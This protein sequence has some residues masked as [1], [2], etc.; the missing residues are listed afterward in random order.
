MLKRHIGLRR[1]LVLWAFAAVMA[2]IVSH[3]RSG[4]LSP[5][6]IEQYKDHHPLGAVLLFLSIYAASVVAALPSLPLN[7]AAGY[8]WGGVLGGPY[9]TIGAT[10]G[11]WLSFLVALRFASKVLGDTPTG[12]KPGAGS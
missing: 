7:L 5:A 9:S 2:L 1:L 11:G 6:T 3:Y 10:L 8:F 4:A 12:M